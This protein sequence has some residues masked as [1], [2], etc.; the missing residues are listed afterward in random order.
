[1]KLSSFLIRFIRKNKDSLNSDPE[2][3]K[4][5][6]CLV[7]FLVENEYYF[8]LDE[9]LKLIRIN[10]TVKENLK[11]TIESKPIADIIVMGLYNSKKF[12]EI[13]M[14]NSVK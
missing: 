4:N 5:I 6:E 8:F 3:D 1:L 7:K 9:Y 13:S 2:T 11:E 12:F 14:R 10:D